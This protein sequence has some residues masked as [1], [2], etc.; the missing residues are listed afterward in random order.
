MKKKCFVIG[1]GASLRN[2]NWE[3]LRGKDTIVTNMAIFYVPKPK[4]FVT[5]DYTFYLK[6]KPEQKEIFD[7]DLETT[8]IFVADMSLGTPLVEKDG[9]IRD[10]RF[11]LIYDLQPYDLIVKAIGKGGFGYT[12]GDFRTGINSGYCALQAAI[13]LGYEEI[14]LLGYDLK[15]SEQTHFHDQYGTNVDVFRE[16]IE[17]YYNYFESG[18]KQLV[19]DNKVTLYSANPNSRLNDLIPAMSFGAAENLYNHE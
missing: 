17:R 18:I 15:A 4:Y 2:F 16:R 13:A 5:V 6:L 9:R 12:F 8:K 19:Q 1:G 14:Y 10:P 7:T 3:Q 11:G